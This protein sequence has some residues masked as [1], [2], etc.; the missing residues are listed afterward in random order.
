MPDLRLEKID[1][2]NFDDF[3][4]LEIYGSQGILREAF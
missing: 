1:Y 4:D 2:K 3:T